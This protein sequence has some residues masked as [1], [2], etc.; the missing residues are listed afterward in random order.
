MKAASFTVGMRSRTARRCSSVTRARSLLVSSTSAIAPSAS[1]RAMPASWLSSRR[2]SVTGSGN[3]FNGATEDQLAA[4]AAAP[5]MAKEFFKAH[6][7]PQQYGRAAWFTM[8]A[9]WFFAVGSRYPAIGQAVSVLLNVLNPELLVVGG[10]LAA[11]GDLLLDGVR[12]SVRLAALP[13]HRQTRI[14]YRSGS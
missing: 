3:D 11:A 2:R 4:L 5:A 13:L 12:E 6:F 14:A 1:A 7:F 9:F 10:D 8:L